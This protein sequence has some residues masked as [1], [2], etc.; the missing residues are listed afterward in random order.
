MCNQDNSDVKNM[1]KY[2]DLGLA[3][4]V[5]TKWALGVFGCDRD[6]L[7]IQ[8]YSFPTDNILFEVTKKGD[9]RHFF[10]QKLEMF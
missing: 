9:P 7:D 10:I 5:C 1:S 6:D 4:N 3:R 2:A 8:D